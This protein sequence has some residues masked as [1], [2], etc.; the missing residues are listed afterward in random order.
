MDLI[1]ALRTT[2]SIRDFTDDPVSDETLWRILDSARFAPSAMN[3][4]GWRVI[5]VH[6]EAARI[7][8]RDL[9]LDGWFGTPTPSEAPTSGDDPD[10]GTAAAIERHA[11]RAAAAAA[12]GNFG[13]NLH[14]LPAL[15]TIWVD[16]SKLAPEDRPSD[17]PAFVA[18]T[19]I[20]PFVWSVLLAARN[21]GLGG[22]LTTMHL[23]AETEIAALLNAP[24]QWSLAAVLALGYPINQATRLSR[25]PVHSF[26]SIDRSDGPPLG[27]PPTG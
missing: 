1:E 10:A 19:S 13:A 16:R 17:R 20:Y 14:A 6:D 8:L 24:D 15:V 21:E 23:Y 26:A 9:Y 27:P 18:G 3:R 2:G 25:A 5:V 4:Q 7:R 11:R 22:V 12:A